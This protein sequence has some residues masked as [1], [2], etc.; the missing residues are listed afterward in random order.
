MA[1]IF[2]LMAF[3]LTLLDPGVD[4][5]CRR[6]D[7]RIDCDVVTEGLLR[8]SVDRVSDEDLR[9]ARLALAP[10]PHDRSFKRVELRSGPSVRVLAEFTQ[11]TRADAV[12][13]VNAFLSDAS[14]RQIAARVAG[15][16]PTPGQRFGVFPFQLIGLLCLAG[17]FYSAGR[18]T[19]FTVVGDDLVVRRVRWPAAAGVQRH[20]LR[21]IA[22]VDAVSRIPDAYATVVASLP[23]RNI[24]RANALALRTTSDQEILITDWSK[25]RRALHERLAATL[26]G[27][28]PPAG[29]GQA[30]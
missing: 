11:K 18:K 13:A 21:D 5:A 9:G 3:G 16:P 24:Y 20:P 28:L 1:P 30:G 29:P 12:R 7:G 10:E 14:S 17:G 6:Q 22:R 23:W 15:S 4:I 8:P 2:A 27:W 25:R 19:I 26:R